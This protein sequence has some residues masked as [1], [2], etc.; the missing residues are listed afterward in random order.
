KTAVIQSLF[1]HH[2]KD[3]ITRALTLTYFL[4][5]FLTILKIIVILPYFSN[6]AT[7]IL[8]FVIVSAAAIALCVRAAK[9]PHLVR[10]YYHVGLTVYVLYLAISIFLL[11]KGINISTLQEFYLVIMWAF[12]GLGMRWGVLYALSTIGMAVIFLVYSN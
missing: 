1:L 5:V 9:R 3:P 8:V 12:F 10:R 11:S 2:I 4:S 7:R 6:D